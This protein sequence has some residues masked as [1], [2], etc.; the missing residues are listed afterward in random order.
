VDRHRPRRRSPPDER[1]LSLTENAIRRFSASDFV[2][3]LLGLVG[4][5]FLVAGL[6][7]VMPFSWP[8][9]LPFV[10]MLG[11]VLAG[12]LLSRRALAAGLATG[13]LAWA[14]FLWWLLNDWSRGMQGF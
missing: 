14:V 13:T 6:Y 12:W 2:N 10:I 8:L 1:T 4:A 3:F 9:V 5:P 7:R 11:T